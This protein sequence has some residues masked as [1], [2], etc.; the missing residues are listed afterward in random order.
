MWLGYLTAALILVLSQSSEIQRDRADSALPC[1][2][3]INNACPECCGYNG[4]DVASSGDGRWDINWH[5]GSCGKKRLLRRSAILS[6]AC[7]GPELVLHVEL[8][9]C[10]IDASLGDTSLCCSACPALPFRL[11]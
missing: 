9:W 11:P 8:V 4:V 1:A 5:L 7:S 10:D 2:A 6:A 3:A